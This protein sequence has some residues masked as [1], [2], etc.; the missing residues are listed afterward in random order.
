MGRFLTVLAALAST[1]LAVTSPRSLGSDITILVDNDLQGEAIHRS[2]ANQDNLTQSRPG[3]LRRCLQRHLPLPQA[4]VEQRRGIVQG[5]RRGAVDSG[6]QT[7]ER[8]RS[9]EER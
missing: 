6:V 7:G 5:P 1:A 2:P 9:V 3:R 4:V 8:R